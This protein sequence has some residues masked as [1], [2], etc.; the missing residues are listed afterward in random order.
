[1]LLPALSKARDKARAISCTNNQKQ[2]LLA[3]NMYADDYEKFVPCEIK[4]AAIM[5]AAIGPM[6]G[7]CGW[8]A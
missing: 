3:N 4:M 5:A 6:A 1:M 7:S 8:N 2:I